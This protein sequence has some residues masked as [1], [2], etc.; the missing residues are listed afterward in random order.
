[1]AVVATKA[2]A[3]PATPNSKP[4]EGRRLAALAVLALAVLAALYAIF[5]TWRQNERAA[6]LDFYI[7]FV[8]AQLPGRA[9]VPNIYDRDVQFRLGE[10]YFE[11]AQRSDSELRKYDAGRR[12]W[13]DSVSSPFLYTSLRWLSRDYERALTQYH[14]LVLFAFVAGFVMIA[15]R[16]RLSWAATSF[17]L[18]ATLLWYRGF[19][20]DIR[21]GNVNSL[22]LLALGV[23]VW[24]PPLLAGAML[25]ML[26][27]FKPN[28]VIAV[29]LLLFSRIAARAWPRLRL[30][31]IGGVAGVFAAIVAAAVNYGSFAV[32]MQWVSA[33][34][35]F[36]H[37]LQTRAERN[38][39]PF[40]LHDITFNYIVTLILTVLVCIAIWRRKVV[41]D[42]LVIGIAIVIYLIAAPVVWLHYMV[43][44]LPL[45]LALMPSGG[46]R[47]FVAG[48]ALLLI[49]E[50]PIEMLTHSPV[51]P[52]DAAFIGPALFAL[53]AC[54][55]WRIAHGAGEAPA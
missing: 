54:G 19:E 42:L 22:Q 3:V 25:G 9:D 27:A 44:A 50:E 38:V 48:L 43:L 24:S 31:V 52:H 13:I 15:R 8:N 17:L 1:M 28:L 29:A 30:E 6:G 47:P 32:W 33:A 20:A 37:R 45:A 16:V 23:A 35:G 41:D 55:I 40:L 11:R 14:A 21:V 34:N 51:F 36:F 46:A 18:A 26:V 4:R 53:F 5:A 49:A 10:E 12:R 7:Y 2:V 39:A